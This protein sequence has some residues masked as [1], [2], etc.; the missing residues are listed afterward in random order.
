MD[1]ASTLFFSL[2]PAAQAHL[3]AAASHK[4]PLNLRKLTRAA[5]PY[6]QT[7]ADAQGIAEFLANEPISNLETR[8][9]AQLQSAISIR[10]GVVVSVS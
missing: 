6:V 9:R 4:D 7:L 5:Y 2:P 10:P 1:E 8:E 3:R